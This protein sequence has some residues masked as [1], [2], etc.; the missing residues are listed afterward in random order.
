MATKIEDF[1]FQ[2]TVPLD[3]S[4]VEKLEAGGAVKVA[5]S[6]ARGAMQSQIVKLDGKGGGKAVFGFNDMPGGAQVILGPPD[7]TDAELL[8]LQTITV[9]VPA[10]S[11]KLKPRFELP[12]VQITTHYWHFWLRWCRIFTIT[13][14]VRCPDGRP[15][16]GAKVCAYDVDWLWWWSS[17]QL[18][19]CDVTDA[20]GAFTLKFRWC[21]GFWP[22]WWWKTRYWQLDPL[23]VDHIGPVLQKDPKL[24]RLLRPDV[25]PSIAEFS[26]LLGQGAAPLAKGEALDPGVFSTIRE[27]LAAALPAS[28]ELEKL[29]IWPWYP[30]R[31]WADCAPD[32]IFRVTQEC[33]DTEGHVI[34]DET[35]WQTRWDIGTNTNVLLVANESACCAPP[36]N[37]CEDGNCMS[38]T[39]VCS[40]T[41]DN[42][43][44]NPGLSSGVPAALVGY[45]GPGDPGSLSDRPFAGVVTIS[46]TAD[47]M[48]EVD[49]YEFEWATSNAGPWNT[50]PPAANGDVGRT[51][52][53][54]MPFGF[55]GETFSATIPVDGRHVYETVQHFEDTHPPADWGGNRLWLGSSRDILI[56]WQTLNNFPDGL[57]YLRVRGWDIDGAGKL[58]KDRI[59]QICGNKAD[60]VLALRLNN[61]LP[62]VGPPD[63]H[64]NPCGSGTVHTCTNQ[65]DTA[66]ISVAIRKSDGST[67]ALGSCGNSSVKE[68]DTLVID[69]V[70]HDP[71]GHLYGFDIGVH[72]DVNLVNDLLA[73]GTL[74]PSPIVVPGV[75]AAAQTGP[76]YANA[77]MQG[78]VRPVWNGGAIRL[79]VPATGPGG[80]FPY[81]C[82]Y[83]LKLNAYKRTIVDC[84][85]SVFGH[86]NTSE[87]SFTIMV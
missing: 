35:L 8:G 31:A 15:V 56:N 61:R 6:G 55:I 43:G 65:P 47:C 79:E 74:T 37:N 87:Y 86:W 59:L 17:K 4:K 54:F 40:D 13:G 7:A 73:I 33:A 38:F 78:A 11:W 18:I 14:V 26:K 77:L 5:V 67:V 57:Y 53:R 72:Y 81:T 19:Q 68:G 42:I 60:A 66:F 49:Y 12:A 25:V 62:L 9:D 84:G 64:G 2:L 63:L 83:G 48:D 85:Y 20:N 16:P 51:Y 82:C 46:G 76:A 28:Q 34:L 22:W 41:L 80:A 44:G 10:R 32:V 3:A 58:I 30:W 70:A 27:K 23:L 50:M 1:K 29:R 69:F 21:C 39:Q 24:P 45:Q 36:R 52:L 71:D 75:P